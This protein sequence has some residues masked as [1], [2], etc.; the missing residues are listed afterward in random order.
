[1]AKNKYNQPTE[2]SDAISAE[3]SQQWLNTVID[4]RLQYT[5]TTRIIKSVID[6]YVGSHEFVLKIKEYASEAYEDKIFK[7]A[8]YWT[9]IV[10]TTVVTSLT[11]YLLGK[12]LK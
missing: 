11:A 4:E 9:S 3:L 10:G 2:V 12:F 1:M 8:R 6:E 7:S 5:G